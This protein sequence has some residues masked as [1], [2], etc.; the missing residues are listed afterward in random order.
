MV[1][2]CVDIMWVHF[3][4]LAIGAL[5]ATLFWGWYYSRRIRRLIVVYEKA[6]SDDVINIVN[7][8]TSVDQ[9]RGIHGLKPLGGE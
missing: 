7:G 3:A 4:E 2:S 9:T 5:C 8:R 6:W 1:S